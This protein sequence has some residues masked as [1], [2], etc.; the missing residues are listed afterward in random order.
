MNEMNRI[1][2]N[3]RQFSENEKLKSDIIETMDNVAQTTKEA[4]EL[5]KMFNNA[6]AANRAHID[7]TIANVDKISQNFIVTSDKLDK[8]MD[9][10]NNI[11]GDET[12][13][14]EIKDSMSDLKDTMSN[15]KE[16]T[17]SV[18]DM[19]TDQKLQTDVK[20]TVES[21]KKTMDN[22]DVAL[23]GFSKMIKAVNETEVAPDFYFRYQTHKQ[24]YFADMNLRIFPPG[25]KVYYLL[26]F[27]DL[28]ESSTTNLQFAVSGTE[29]DTWYRF[30]IKSGK[31]GIGAERVR[32]NMF[33]DAELV[34]PNDLQLDLRGGREL[35]SDAY[36][37]LGWESVLKK[38]SLSLGILQRY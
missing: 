6:G 31:L 14:K 16:T 21:T 26:G 7:D 5:V 12:L 22:A 37:M 18:K 38:D 10:V 35:W 36:L 8:L 11:A 3:A 13:K 32:K 27:D 28:G 30:G 24:Q 19:L 1:L 20:E 34:D 17:K 23:R 9:H 25:K 33:Y 15:L 29:P 4:S 2:V